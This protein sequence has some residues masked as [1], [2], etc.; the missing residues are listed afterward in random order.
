[1][2]Y[3]KLISFQFWKLSFRSSKRK[4]LVFNKFLEN[5]LGRFSHYQ[6]IA[7]SISVK[8]SFDFLIFRFLVF[9]LFSPLR[10]SAPGIRFLVGCV[11]LERVFPSWYFFTTIFNKIAMECVYACL[12]CLYTLWYVLRHYITSAALP[13]VCV[14]HV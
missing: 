1:M 6:V 4:Q 14:C 7:S 5:R 8:Y 2:K 13:Y 12:G 3:S 11:S 10:S 9:C